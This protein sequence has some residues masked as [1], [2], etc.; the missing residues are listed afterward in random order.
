M[1]RREFATLGG[2]VVMASSLTARAQQSGKVFRLGHLSGG[3]ADSRVLLISE[4]MRGMSDHGYIEGKNLVVKHRY[5]EG[6]FEI[7]PAL[8][9]D[10]LA[11]NPDVL[12]VSTTPATLAAKAATS[13]VPIV[14][15]SVADPVGA[16]LVASLSRPGGNITGITNIGAELA[17]KRLEI[18]K[19]IVAATA[20]VAVLINLNDQNAQLQLQNAR[21]AADKLGVG[22]EP[23]LHI[24]TSA[25]LKG[26]FEAA[27]RAGAGAALRMIDPLITSLRM[28]TVA[29]AAE[30]RLPVMY[31]FREDVAAGGLVSYG[32]SLPAQYRQAAG[33]VHKL[34]A[35]SKPADIPVSQPTKFELVI[36]LK[37]AKALGLTIPQSILARADEVIE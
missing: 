32:P 31:A 9:R 8:A 4:F 22:L 15:V 29:L 12:F 26:A 5:A 7:L 28:Q 1:R 16:G 19:E 6:R 21:L 13:T 23:V 20:T 35:G 2:G 24:G 36:N 17:G 37:T 18:L 10:V 14:M 25:D 30:H 27:T 33:F 11:W 34:F 3:N